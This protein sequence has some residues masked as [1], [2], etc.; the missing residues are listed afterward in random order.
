MNT[1]SNSS[2]QSPGFVARL[3]SALRT[4][5]VDAVGRATFKHCTSPKALYVTLI[6]RWWIIAI[7]ALAGVC[8]GVFTIK[9][10]VR[11]F[12]SHGKILVYQ[13]LPTFMDDST[14]LPD[15]KAYDSLF[16]THVALIGSPLIIE[17]AVKDHDL[18]NR[19]PE[20]EPELEEN[21]QYAHYIQQHLTTSRAGSGDSKGAFVISVGF[22]H[23]SAKECP[24]VVEAILE[25]YRDYTNSSI[26]DDQTRAVE[27]M[28]DIRTSMESD[29]KAK[30]LAYREFMKTATGVWDRDT[31][32]NT[33]QKRVEAMQT[34]LTTLELKKAATES[35]IRIMS[36]THDRKTGEKL[37]D[38]ARLALIDETHIS[39]LEM[40]LSVKG[41]GITELYQNAYPEL[42]EYANARFKQL[43]E[44]L[45]EREELVKN[46]GPNH[47][48]VQ[49]IDSKIGML[50]SLLDSSQKKLT[51]PAS[52]NSLEPADIIAAY[53]R[54]L[55]EELNDAND[56]IAALNQTIDTQ[57]AA[58]KSLTDFTI[59]ATQ[60]EDD[61][62]RSKDLYTALIDKA[63]KQQVLSQFGSY[64]AEIIAYPHFKGQLTWPKKPVILAL[65]T[66]LGIFVGSFLALALDLIAFTPLKKAFWFVPQWLVMP[67][68]NH[69][70]SA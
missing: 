66:I 33:H 25:T 43:N 53:V 68:R 49:D 56:R 30:G 70:G 54:M 24:I 45:L 65:C 42:Q 3:F 36:H 31:E 64:V 51:A 39:R 21:R 62:Q 52:K 11:Q 10:A 37:S 69:A 13:K 6:E 12:E 67:A 28:S 1:P 26:L 63:Q 48:K 41:E 8:A 17:K 14:R 59:H 47:P 60:L 20:I 2:T 57:I 15:P 50:E 44:L 46:I 34:E 23:L 61:Y 19:C 18:I 5:D 7:C 40:L 27:V 55:D 4:L 32:N 29:V 9:T 16:A 38:L 58:A 22:D 35:R